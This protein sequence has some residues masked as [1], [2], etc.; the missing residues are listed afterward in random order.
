MPYQ[1]KYVCLV[2]RSFLKRF[3]PDKSIFDVNLLHFKQIN[4][5]TNDDF[6]TKVGQ[7]TT[8]Y[9][10]PPNLLICITIQGLKSSITKSSCQKPNK[11]E[12][13]KRNFIIG[14]TDG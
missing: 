3:A 6:L 10:L 2:K 8:E 13:I 1:I 9:D 12:K 4:A 11:H 7:K 5:E 14:R